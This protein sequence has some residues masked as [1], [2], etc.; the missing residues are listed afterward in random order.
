MYLAKSIAATGLR[1]QQNRL[2]VIANNVANANTV[3]FKSPRLDFK[4]ALYTW[5]VTPGPPRNPEMNQQRGHGVMIAGIGRD[6]RTGSFERTERATDFAIQ[7]EGFFTLSNPD[8]GVLYTRN[9]SFHLSAEAGGN[10]L[11]NGEGLYVLDTN[12]AR[13]TI[14]VGV[15]TINV[16]EDGTLE[17]R[18]GDNLVGGATLNI[19]T[20]RNIGGLESVGQ[21]NFAHTPSAGEILPARN[22]VIRQGILEGSNINL[23][24]EMT[25][26][27]RTQRAFQLSSRALTTADDMEGIA[28]NMRR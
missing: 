13:I 6:W 16:G 20:F 5:G 3:A 7:G 22:A 11:V 28:N 8:G 21:S 1:N 26:L 14:P 2:D 25:R 24:E 4:D 15:S 9:G 19:A 10:F 27:I 12:G 18:I 17:F 23:A